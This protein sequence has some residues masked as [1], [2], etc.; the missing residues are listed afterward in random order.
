MGAEDIRLEEK[1][2]A[3]LPG[4]LLWAIAGWQS[5]HRRGHFVQPESSQEAID[6]IQDLASP[7]SAFVRDM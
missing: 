2:T 7:I 6:E 4:I 3:E 1:L 5:L